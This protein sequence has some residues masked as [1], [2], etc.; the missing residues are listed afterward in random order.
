MLID[1]RDIKNAILHSDQGIHYINKAYQHLLK[2]KGIILSVS[3]KETVGIIAAFS[4]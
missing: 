2:E 1:R 4:V 3:R